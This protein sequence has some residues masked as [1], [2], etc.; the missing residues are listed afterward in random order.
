M[1]GRNA[2]GEIDEV[3]FGAANDGAA[4]LA[5]LDADRE[6]AV[7]P[8]RHRVHRR[9]A[10]RAIRVSLRP[11]IATRE[12][13]NTHGSVRTEKERANERTLHP[14]SDHPNP[15]KT[16]CISANTNQEEV[17]QRLLLVLDVVHREVLQVHASFLVLHHRDSPA[18]V[19]AET[20]VRNEPPLRHSPRSISR[21]TPSLGCQTARTGALRCS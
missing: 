10:D 11:I 19:H 4:V 16:G 9:L 21:R 8:R 3:Q 7:R 18:G 14:F 12:E 5:S 2:P 15:T 6:D 13:N 1:G 20:N 17:V